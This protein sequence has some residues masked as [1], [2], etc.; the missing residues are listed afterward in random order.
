MPRNKKMAKKKM[1]KD[2]KILNELAELLTAM[3]EKKVVK[4]RKNAPY[5]FNKKAIIES[6]F[7]MYLVSR[8]NFRTAMVD[9]PL[10]N[11]C[12]NSDKCFE[13]L[14]N[15]FNKN[16]KSYER[17]GQPKMPGCVLASWDDT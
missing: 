1:S 15:F 7:G 6:A 16:L 17:N 5:K 2:R 3:V 11:D 8:I 12:L 9:V 4:P 10:L 14:T 13:L